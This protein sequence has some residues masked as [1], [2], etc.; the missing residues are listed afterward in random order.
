MCNFLC[1]AEL[2]W[3]TKSLSKPV[4]LDITPCLAEGPGSNPSAREK[5]SWPQ[6]PEPGKQGDVH[7]RGMAVDCMG[8]CFPSAGWK[9]S[10]VTSH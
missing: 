6:R 7:L 5:V 9:C 1:L 3:L 8:C 2:R 10:Q 4:I